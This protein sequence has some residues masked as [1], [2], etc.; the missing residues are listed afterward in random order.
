MALLVRSSCQ[1]D[2]EP[3]PSPRERRGERTLDG[4]LD[5]ELD[6]ELER[7]HGRLSCPVLSSINIE[8]EEPVI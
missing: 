4:E 2:N 6:C 7:E 1:S 3:G 8:G 5:C